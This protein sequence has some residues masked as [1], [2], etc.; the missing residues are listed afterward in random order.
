MTAS[1]FEQLSATLTCGGV[2]PA[3]EQ[4]ADH[5]R[6][7]R[8]YHEL[9]D[10]RLMQAR[11]QL[12]LSIVGTTPLDE[13]PEPQRS[14]LE[15][16][17]L[18]ACREVGR[19]LLAAGNIRE[20]WVYLRP[21]GE[22]NLVAEALQKAQPTDENMDELIGVALHEGVAPAFGYSL[23]LANYGTCNAITT[24]DAEM[25]RFA[26]AD[27]Q[28]AAALLLKQLHGDLAGNVRHHVAQQEGAEPSSEATLD[29]LVMGRD[30]LFEGGNYHTDT[31]HLNSA[32]RIARILED[33]E[34]VRLA[35][36][37]AEYGRR[38]D[39]QYHFS[40]EEPFADVYPSH[41]LFYGAQI[42]KQV[43]E[44][45]AYFRDK[46]EGLKVQ[47]EGSLPAEV[48]ITLLARL[49]RLS[50]ATEASARLLPAGTRTTGFAPSLLELS[51]QAGDYSVLAR[52]SRDRGELLP[53]AV[54]LI[55]GRK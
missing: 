46:A 45:L 44:S 18:E 8:R 26:R 14:Q 20:A 9:F 31:T 42:G 53:Y 36:E 6:S 35:W 28:A 7:L 12:G 41:C 5:F 10:T 3:L 19:L 27:Q 55:A 23:I 33:R 17:Y 30:W 4:L 51:R 29:Q 43:D 38:L 16:A 49:G 37:L 48:Y 52:T 24:F 34:L 13:L 50:E 54:A 1:P 25:G 22:A 11:H 21:A 2:E 39:K 15:D 47:D 40:A 32:I